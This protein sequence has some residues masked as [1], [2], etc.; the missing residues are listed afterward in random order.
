M[1]LP[2]SFRF[3]SGSNQLERNR[4]GELD[5]SVPSPTA[6]YKVFFMVYTICPLEKQ[7]DL[8]NSKVFNRL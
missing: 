5:A 7:D 3:P 6:D 1:H 4:C 2:A 8:G